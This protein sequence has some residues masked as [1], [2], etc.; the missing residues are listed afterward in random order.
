MLSKLTTI[1]FLFVILIS[2]GRKIQ[3]P[4]ENS[5]FTR[6]TSHKELFE[7]VKEAETSS[8][9][10]T[11]DT[12][13]LSAGGKI[14][15]YL[16]ISQTEFGED[17]SKIKVLIFAQQHGNE[18]V[19]KEASLILL[20]KIVNREFDDIFTKIDLLL[21]PQM[22]PDGS[23]ADKRRNGNDED[24]NRDHLVLSQ[25]ETQALHKL[26]Q[27]YKPQVTLDVHEYNPYSKSWMEYGYIKNADVQFGG[28]TNPNVSAELIE[29]QKKK[30]IPFIEK[31]LAE[32]KVTFQEYILGGPPEIER[33][34]YST[35]D[36]NDGRQS[37]GILNS[38]SFI[39]EGKNGRDSKDNL[40]Y[41]SM[42]QSEALAGF[43][44]FVFLNSEEIKTKVESAKL[45]L[46]KVNV[47][48]KTI[49]RMEHF[50]NGEKLSL[51]LKSTFTGRDT[52]VAVNEFHPVVESTLIVNNPTGY[53]ISKSH[54]KLKSFLDKHSIEYS[55][56]LPVKDHIVKAYRFNLVK[57]TID[58]ELKNLY[59]EVVKETVEIKKPEN[60]YYVP[61]NQIA[62]NL[63][64][65]AF[66][67][68]SMLGL[69]QY[70]EFFPST[71][72]EIFPI[73]RVERLN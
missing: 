1:F 29:I 73:Y 57:E 11:M 66:E 23:D 2:C 65:T 6:L 34:R 46:R 42:S 13:G 19:G 70:E 68:Q 7:F 39:M 36:I 44:K 59:P 67:P 47:N 69:L 43:L 64:V 38:L 40:K 26:Y 14:I 15:P 18:Q 72:F 71:E 41:R 50:P 53:L 24:L 52:N 10:I 27:K 12:L 60:Y 58:E 56:Y 30:F 45:K 49:I 4:L 32:K 51:N 17:T 28:C 21:V 62:S 3:T 48:D 63:L 22:N 25:P 35:V 61:V 16:K 31:Y 54:P 20:S 9:L 37:F 55:E 5:D 8:P 33:M